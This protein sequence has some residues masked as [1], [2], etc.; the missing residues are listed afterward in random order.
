MATKT[1]TEKKTTEKSY[2]SSLDLVDRVSAAVSTT[3]KDAKVIVAAVRD[4]I[5]D[6]LKEKGQVR[7]DGLGT[8]RVSERAERMGQNPR[9]GEKV[10]IPASRVVCF[11]GG[12]ALREA[13]TK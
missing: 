8:F 3:K 5:V 7:I 13:L 10:T 1:K 12:K 6:M 4:S 2:F 11:R 9:T